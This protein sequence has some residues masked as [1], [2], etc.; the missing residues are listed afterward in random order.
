MDNYTPPEVYL[1]GGLFIV[2]IPFFI[3]ALREDLRR[4]RIYGPPKRSGNG[5]LGF[6]VAMLMFDHWEE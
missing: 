1:C 2:S 5:F 4:I 6:L 3:K